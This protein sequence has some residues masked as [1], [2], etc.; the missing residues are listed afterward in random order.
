M[1]ENRPQQLGTF[2]VNGEWVCG[3]LFADCGEIRSLPTGAERGVS[4]TV[5]YYS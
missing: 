3:G 5:T 4:W 1:L 2:F